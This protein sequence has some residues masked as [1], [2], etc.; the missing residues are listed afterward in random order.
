MSDFQSLRFT[1]EILRKSQNM[2]EKL[3]ILEQC[4][5]PPLYLDQGMRSIGYQPRRYFG[6]SI[7]S[8]ATLEALQQYIDPE[9]EVLEIGS[10]LGLYAFVFGSPLFCKRWI[11]TDHPDT[12]K[13]WLP[14]G[15]QQPFAPV[16]LTPSPLDMFSCGPKEKRVLI[17][18]WPEAESMYFWEDYVT[19]FDGQTVIIIGTP[20]VTGSEEMWDRLSEAFPS[21]FKAT[22]VCKINLGL[23][24]NYEMIYVWSRS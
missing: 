18:V 12:Y 1:A 7:P 3:W 9:S 8:I 22:T 2:E 20:G 11:A 15:T 21:R 16:Y 4:F 6:Y 23:I 19:K 24:F 14:A 13:D 10:C 5:T 17:T